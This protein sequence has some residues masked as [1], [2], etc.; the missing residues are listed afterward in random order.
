MEEE[1]K[2]D[3]MNDIFIKAFNESKDK[4]ENNVK[5]QDYSDYDFESMNLNKYRSDEE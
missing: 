1:K 3:E 4:S 5:K 2:S